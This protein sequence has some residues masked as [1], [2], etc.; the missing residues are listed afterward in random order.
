M[1]QRYDWTFVFCGVCLFVSGA[2][3]FVIPRLQRRK[4]GFSPTDKEAH[5]GNGRATLLDGLDLELDEPKKV[6][7]VLTSAS[8]TEDHL[9][10]S[11]TLLERNGPGQ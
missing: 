5:A 2:M 6:K 3:L 8:T 9:L 11:S 10:L 1:T 4:A 7:R